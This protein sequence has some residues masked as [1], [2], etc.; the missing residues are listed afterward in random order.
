MKFKSNIIPKC[1]NGTSTKTGNA[2]RSVE[3]RLEQVKELLSSGE[4]F[5]YAMPR[6]YSKNEITGRLGSERAIYDG[7]DL[8]YI[9]RNIDN[10]D[11]VWLLPQHAM[12]KSKNGKLSLTYMGP[13]GDTDVSDFQEYVNG[14]KR[15]AD[16]LYNIKTKIPLYSDDD[17]ERLFYEIDYNFRN[18]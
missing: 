1:Q 4:P 7:K 15:I 5:V 13:Y 3:D 12:L 18:K 11:T 8:D 17:R 16:S 2:R 10:G 14:S 9:S 6:H